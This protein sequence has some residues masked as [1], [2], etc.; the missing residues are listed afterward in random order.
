[1]LRIPARHPHFNRVNYVYAVNFF[2]FI[3]FKSLWIKDCDR[4]QDT[5]SYDPCII[6]MYI[7]NSVYLTNMQYIT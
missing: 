2:D 5:A 7:Y 4:V 3:S 1:M 6:A